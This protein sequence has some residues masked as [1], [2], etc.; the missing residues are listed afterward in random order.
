MG[1]KS[2]TQVAN[3]A[4]LPQMTNGLARLLPDVF[5][6]IEV[7]A[8]GREVQ[9]VQLRVGL[10]ELAGWTLVPGGTIQEQ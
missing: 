8:A 1:L 10:D 5:L 2:L 6:G 9:H 7:R 4:I 3:M